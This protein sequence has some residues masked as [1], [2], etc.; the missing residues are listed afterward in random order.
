MLAV[1]SAVLAVV[2]H[3]AAGG[4]LP[5]AGLTALLTVGVAAA[6]VALA[7]RRR[8][9]WVIVAVLG[10]AQLAI[11]VL[12]SVESVATDQAGM[13]PM[14]GM[15]FDGVAMIGAHT[16]AVLVS[17]G[18]LA[19]ADAAMFAL[20]ALLAKVLPTVLYVPAA[21]E[22]PVRAR[23]FPSPVDRVTV[24]ILSRQ[25]NARRGPPVTA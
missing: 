16:I 9:P 15:P 8:S 19:K 1:T 7:G 3:A 12:L 20:T 14:R 11:H 22:A 4:V 5:S 17:A 13:A 21:P 6:G 2:A 10:A 23:P 18:L 24:R 25:V